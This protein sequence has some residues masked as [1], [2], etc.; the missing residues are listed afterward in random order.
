VITFTKDPVKVP[1]VG[2]FSIS[3]QGISFFRQLR[4]LRE[5]VNQAK[6]CRL[7][8]AQGAD[9]CGFAAVIAGKLINKPVVIKFVGDLSV[10]MERDFGKKIWYLFYIT[11]ITL[12]LANRIIFPAKHL[13]DLI[14]GKYKIDKNKTRVIYNAV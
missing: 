11:K 9:V 6:D 2:V 1:G 4:L 7:I 8:Y 10:E 14:C 12:Y 5:I 13:Q 3:T